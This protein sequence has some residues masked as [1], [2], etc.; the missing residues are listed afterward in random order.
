MHSDYR[1]SAIVPVF[2]GWFWPFLPC[3][4]WLLCRHRFHLRPAV[5]KAGGFRWQPQLASSF[6]LDSPRTT[7]QLTKHKMTHTHIYILYIYIFV[8][9]LQIDSKLPLAL[10]LN[11]LSMVLLACNSCDGS[12]VSEGHWVPMVCHVWA[13]P[14]M[15]ALLMWKHIWRCRS[16]LSTTIKHLSN[17]NLYSLCKYNIYIYM[18][19]CKLHP[20]T[21]P[22]TPI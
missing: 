22:Y 5:I 11:W 6:W 16:C 1:M 18:S 2:S 12:Q 7:K 4:R 21:P 13:I 15:V 3:L 10:D 20:H 14:I 8:W 17:S 19:L 9:R